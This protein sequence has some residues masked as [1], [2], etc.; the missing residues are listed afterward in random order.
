MFRLNFSRN[1]DRLVSTV[2]SINNNKK[3]LHKHNMKK[4][5]VSS[6]TTI[7]KLNK[8]C[9]IFSVSWKHCARINGVRFVYHPPLNE[10]MRIDNRDIC[11]LCEWG[12]NKRAG[13]LQ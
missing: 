5:L 1:T 13:Y 11:T 4:L 8:L 12:N 7:K 10:C 3:E 9:R 6:V 2:M